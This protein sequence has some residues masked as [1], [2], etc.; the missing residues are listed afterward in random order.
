MLEL[1][2]CYDSAISTYEEGLSIRFAGIPEIQIANDIY[3][4]VDRHKSITMPSDAQN[5]ALIYDQDIMPDRQRLYYWLDVAPVF[6]IEG[7]AEEIAIYLNEQHELSVR[8]IF[9]SVNDD[10]DRVTV[11]EPAGKSL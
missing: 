11:L 3:G 8:L 4:L 9:K 10:P 2:P 5:A 1:S 7:V 6:E